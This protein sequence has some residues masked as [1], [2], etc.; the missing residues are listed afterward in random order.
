M[1]FP[2]ELTRLSKPPTSL[3]WCV[4]ES[5]FGSMRSQWTPEGGLHTLQLV[6]SNTQALDPAQQITT[7]EL[8]DKRLITLWSNSRE[9]DWSPFAVHITASDL[10]WQVWQALITIPFAA[11]CAYQAIA[12]QIER[13]KAV[14]AVGSAIGQN[15]IFYLIPCHRVLRSNGSLGG[16]YWGIDIK[17]RILDWERSYL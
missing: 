14:R 5:P 4:S 10:Q 12:Q 15:P 9:I 13:P 8:P 17:Q 3:R 11:T 1:Q 6:T 2:I 16:Y 7:D